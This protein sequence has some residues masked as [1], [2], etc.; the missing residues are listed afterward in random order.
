MAF[1]DL[2]MEKIAAAWLFVSGKLRL[3]VEIVKNSVERR[4]IDGEIR[5]D[6]AALGRA[7]Y[8][9]KGRDMDACREICDRL[10]ARNEQL[11]A[12][13][14]RST[15]MLRRRRC[16][17]CNAVMGKKARFCSECGAAMPEETKE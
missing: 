15:Q 14:R 1:F 12:L 11:E 7:V 17:E 8:D 4:R 5:R 10:D 2:I 16:P 6:Y 13:T 3:G 9:S